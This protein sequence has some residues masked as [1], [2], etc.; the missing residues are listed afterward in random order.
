MNKEDSTSKIVKDLES[1]ARGG[2]IFSEGRILG[3]EMIRSG[4]RGD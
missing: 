2:R 4:P 1:N 3:R